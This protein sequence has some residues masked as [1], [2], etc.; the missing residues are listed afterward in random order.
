MDASRASAKIDVWES[1]LS[2][3]VKNAY[4]EIKGGRKQVRIRVT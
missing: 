2:E 4:K 1:G 3:G